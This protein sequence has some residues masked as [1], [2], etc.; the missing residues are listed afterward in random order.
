MPDLP[1]TEQEQRA[2]WD[3]L[4]SDIEYRQAQLRLI[5][6]QS[7]WETPRAIAMMALALAALIAAG[8]LTDLVWPSGPQAIAVHFDQPIIVHFD[9]QKGP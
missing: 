5:Y 2:K 7:R 8:R 1:N 9:Q 6:R 3:L 4:L